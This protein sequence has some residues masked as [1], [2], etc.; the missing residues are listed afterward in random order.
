MTPIKIDITRRL[1]LLAEATGLDYEK[2]LAE[3]KDVIK[4]LPPAR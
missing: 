4:R 2:L 3:A 1:R